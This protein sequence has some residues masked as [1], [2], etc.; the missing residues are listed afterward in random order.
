MFAFFNTSC[1]SHILSLETH[2]ILTMSFGIFRSLIN[3][4][5]QDKMLINSELLQFRINC[6]KKQL[7]NLKSEDILS[8][9]TYKLERKRIIEQLERHAQM[10]KVL[11]DIII[12]YSG[13][14]YVD[15]L[16]T[17]GNSVELKKL[18]S[19]FDSRN[20]LKLQN[21]YKIMIYSRRRLM[22]Q[23][24]MVLILNIFDLESLDILDMYSARDS[25][26]KLCEIFHRILLTHF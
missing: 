16:V 9:E 14:V 6:I 5:V 25:Q 10:P 15:A 3:D 20:R 12:S 22:H 23:C 18:V 8:M 11:C 26:L 19:D 2:N 24:Y 17:L 13:S 1:K 7:W 21:I 4:S